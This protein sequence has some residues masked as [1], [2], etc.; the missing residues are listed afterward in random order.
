VSKFPLNGI[1]DNNISST[2][3]PAEQEVHMRRNEKKS[4]G[5]AVD[6]GEREALNG[7]DQS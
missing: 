3:K 6:N 7:S 1:S 5:D 2:I 4:D